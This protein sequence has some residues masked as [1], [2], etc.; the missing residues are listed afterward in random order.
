M[1]NRECDTFMGDNEVD[2]RA[3]AQAYT[4]GETIEIHGLASIEGNPIFNMNLSCARALKAKSLIQEIAASRGIHLNIV[5]YS[6]GPVEGEYYPVNR[7]IAIVRY[8]PIPIHDDHPTPIQEPTPAPTQPATPICSWSS[9]SRE[10]LGI[11]DTI[12]SNVFNCVCLADGILDLKDSAPFLLPASPFIEGLDCVCNIMTILQHIYNIGADDSGCWNLSNITL[13]EKVSL[14]NLAGL[15]FADCASLP[16]GASVGAFILG[17]VGGAGETAA[18]PGAG[19]IV[20]GGGGALTGA[21]LGDFIVDITAMALQN[22]I[23][24]GTPL[25]INQ[26]HSCI[27][28]ANLVGV[29]VNAN[30]LCGEQRSTPEW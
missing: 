15:T 9:F 3:D 12:V 4:D 18:E 5:I 30:T 25:P 7:S 13:G 27:T 8:S 16:I 19:T 1:F 6:R 29:N 11:N 23:T 28:L 14:V 20:G 24:Q 22:I 2:L 10:L 21:M 26:C 17:L